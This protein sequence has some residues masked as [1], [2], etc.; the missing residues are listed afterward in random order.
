[1][2]VLA[3]S[4][5]AFSYFYIVGFLGF[6][7]YDASQE[8]SPLI[9]LWIAAN[10]LALLSFGSFLLSEAQY[11]PSILVVRNPLT[12][13]ASVGVIYVLLAAVGRTPKLWLLGGLLGLYAAFNTYYTLVDYDIVS[14]I[15]ALNVLACVLAAYGILELHVAYR[16]K[17]DHHYV[18]LEIAFVVMILVYVYRAVYTM[19]AGQLSPAQLYQ[20]MLIVSVLANFGFLILWNFFFYIIVSSE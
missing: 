16:R 2:N 9:R 13:A 8:R 1:M 6:I 20:H 19:N 15:Q 4:A 5:V 3:A 17:H 7:Y 12:A 14:R 10:A 18:L 11:G